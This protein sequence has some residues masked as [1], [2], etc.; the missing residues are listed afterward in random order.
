[1]NY[2]VDWYRQLKFNVVN[3]YR[4]N[5]LEVILGI[6][7]LGQK[8]PGYRWEFQYS[9]RWLYK[10]SSKIRKSVYEKCPELITP[11]LRNKAYVTSACEV[12]RQDFP[13]FVLISHSVMQAEGEDDL[14]SFHWA[15]KEGYSLSFY[16][17]RKR[18]KISAAHTKNDPNSSYSKVIFPDYKI[19][20]EQALVVEKIPSLFRI[21]LMVKKEG[22]KAAVESHSREASV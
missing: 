2:A 16:A 5:I 6:F 17:G 20:L 11:C 8:D 13:D 14:Y 19:E 4:D 3:N 22:L 18:L 9:D 12:L 15:D 21:M 10:F 1:M 7:P